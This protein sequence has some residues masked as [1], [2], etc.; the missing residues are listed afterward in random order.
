MRRSATRLSL[1]LA[2]LIMVPG[3]GL[4]GK[5][6]PDAMADTGS[7]PYASPVYDEPVRDYDPYEMRTTWATTEPAGT[8]Y[9]SPARTPQP[10]APTMS[11]SRY[12]TVSK[13]DT[14]YAIARKYY[15]DQ[16]RWK[17]VYEANR[18]TLPDPNMIKTGQRLVIP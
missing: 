11:G 10:A 17:E 7:D 16:R 15:G 5:K 12:H 1:F 3:C 8:V 13:G 2:V 4:F 14:L 9:G 18:S 6:K